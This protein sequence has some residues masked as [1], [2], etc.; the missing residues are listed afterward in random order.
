[1]AAKIASGAIGYFI[2]CAFAMSL[3]VP[4]ARPKFGRFGAGNQLA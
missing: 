1:M 4:S 2:N 3:A